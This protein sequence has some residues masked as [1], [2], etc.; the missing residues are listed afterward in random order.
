MNEIAWTMTG[1]MFFLTTGNGKNRKRSWFC[2]LVLS[3][4][5]NLLD[6]CTPSP[7][8]FSILGTVEVLS[9]PSLRAVDTL[10]AHTA[11]CYCIAI[12]PVGRCVLSNQHLTP[13]LYV[14]NKIDWSFY[15]SKFQ[16]WKPNLM[17]GVDLW[18]IAKCFRNIAGYPFF[19]RVGI[20]LWEVRTL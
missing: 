17:W 4:H 8:C 20:L 16:L 7:C 3:C 12:D 18:V 10:M 2:W 14:N 1:D 5:L 19:P 15:P 9:Y 11:G 13:F 6:Q